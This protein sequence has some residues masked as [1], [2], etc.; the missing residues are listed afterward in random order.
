MVIRSEDLLALR[1]QIRVSVQREV[2]SSVRY[3]LERQDLFELE[4]FE[5]KSVWRA[6]DF[7]QGELF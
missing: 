7:R 5:L 1:Q 2:V 6:V 3:L 4:S